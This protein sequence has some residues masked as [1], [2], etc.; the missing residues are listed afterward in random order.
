MKKGSP[1]RR[2]VL[3]SGP[4]A[5]IARRSDGATSERR[6]RLSPIL[7]GFLDFAHGSNV[8][9]AFSLEQQ[10]GPVQIGPGIQW[11][12]RSGGGD[13]FHRRVVGHAEDENGGEKVR[14]NSGALLDYACMDDGFAV[15]LLF[16]G[17]RPDGDIRPLF[18][19][20]GDGTRKAY[21]AD[22]DPVENGPAGQAARGLEHGFQPEHRRKQIGTIEVV[23]FQIGIG[24]QGR[25]VRKTPP[26]R[27][28]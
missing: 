16:V 10:G 14:P 18:R 4:K 12:G 5:A 26:P 24:F 19:I 13:G 8:L 17:Q 21:V 7:A 9:E 3:L 28:E 2:T 22:P 6:T 25:A 23:V 1:R 15:R 20:D 27:R 11:Q